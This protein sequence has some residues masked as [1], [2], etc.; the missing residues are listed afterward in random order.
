MYLHTTTHYNGFVPKYLFPYCAPPFLPHST[1]RPCKE[2][3]WTGTSG[4][5]FIQ[6][7]W[8]TPNVKFI[9][10]NVYHV[11]SR[12][13]LLLSSS[14]PPSLFTLGKREPGVLFT[15]NHLLQT[16]LTRTRLAHPP[17]LALPHTLQSRSLPPYLSGC[18]RTEPSHVVTIDTTP[19]R[20]FS[21]SRSEPPAK[22]FDIGRSAPSAVYLLGTEPNLSIAAFLNTVSET[23]KR[24]SGQSLLELET[25]KI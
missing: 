21:Y 3:V 18:N 19:T 1:P 23:S 17:S 2:Q 11:D 22:N 24:N 14:G 12:L 7:P 8:T 10:F 5:L 25:L 13:L 4:P 6:Q 9:L 16:S 15:F 20:L